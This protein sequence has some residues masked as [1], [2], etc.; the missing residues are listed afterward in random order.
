MSRFMWLLGPA[1]ALVSGLAPLAE[2]VWPQARVL[3][4][5]GNLLAILLVL[6]VSAIVLPRAAKARGRAHD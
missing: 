3:L 4:A 6:G 1:L 2:R 5:A